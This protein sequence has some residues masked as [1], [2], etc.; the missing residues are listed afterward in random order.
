MFPSDRPRPFSWEP[1]WTSAFCHP[2]TPSHVAETASVLRVT[3]ITW[4]PKKKHI[5][6]WFPYKRVRHILKSFEFII[7]DGCL[8]VKPSLDFCIRFV[9]LS[10]R[11][12]QL[13]TDYNPAVYMIRVTSR[14]KKRSEGHYEHRSKDR[15]IWPSNKEHS[16]VASC[17][18]VRNDWQSSQP[19]RQRQCYPLMSTLRKP[20]VPFKYQILT[21]ISSIWR[22]PPQ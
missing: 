21:Y 4:N 6:K 16:P 2:W 12:K 15:D 20:A 9:G 7:E 13:S 1:L 3:V 8:L 10:W 5:W 19:H 11:V 22:L 18:W 14:D 17:F